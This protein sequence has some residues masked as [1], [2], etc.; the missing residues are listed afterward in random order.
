MK[1]PKFVEL[2]LGYES[3][4]NRVFAPKNIFLQT[5]GILMS[6]KASDYLTN[7]LKQ[8]I[9]TITPLPKFII[10]FLDLIPKIL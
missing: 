7:I 9:S 10:R 5:V 3:R 8:D 1:L 4:E 6:R 2:T